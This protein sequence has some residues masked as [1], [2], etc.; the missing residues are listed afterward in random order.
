[1]AKRKAR[2]IVEAVES[3]APQAAETGSHPTE[4]PPALAAPPASGPQ[5]EQ[6]AAEAQPDPRV[7]APGKG[8]GRGW[9]VDNRVGYRLEDIDTED[10]PGHQIRFADRTS[11]P[12]KPDDE[13]LA[14]VRTRRPPVSYAPRDKAWQVAATPRGRDALTAADEELAEIGRRRTE[15]PGR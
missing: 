11:G 13:L 4:T 6:A 3:A 2:P 5:P 10:G 8:P 7:A 1:M 15:G 9:T 14:T 12:K